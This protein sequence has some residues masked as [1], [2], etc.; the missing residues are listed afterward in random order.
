[1]LLNIMTAGIS[2]NISD[3]FLKAIVKYGNHLN[4]K[5]NKRVSNSSNMFPFDTVDIEKIIRE[6]SSLDYTKVCQES[7]IPTKIIKENGD[8]FSLTSSSSL[9]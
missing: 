8:I 7:D 6:I 5:T 1:M 2:R 9:V 4:I 3:P